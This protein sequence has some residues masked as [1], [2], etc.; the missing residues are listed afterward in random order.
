MIID[1]KILLCYNAPVSIYQVYTGKPKEHDCGV[2]DMSESGFVN[3]LD[4]L[5]ASLKKYFS[6][7]ETLAVSKNI[8]E[9]IRKITA[10][11]PDAIFNLVESV[12]GNAT[13]E[14]FH[15][16]IFDLLDI[17]YTG[18]SPQALGNC[19]NKTFA[20]QIL[21]AHGIKTPGSLTFTSHTHLSQKKFSLQFPVITK[22]A[23]EDA[24]IGISEHSVVSSFENLRK[25]IKF[26]TSTYNQDVI[27]EEYIAGR[28][29]NI[30]VL[31]NR[32]LP[33]SEIDFSGLPDHLPKIVTYEG[34]WISESLY[35]KH[36]NPKCPAKLS[37]YLR[38]N[39][40][41]AALTTFNA[42]ECRDYARVDIRLDKNNIPYVIE[43]NPNPDISTDSGFARAAKASG[44]HYEEMLF[45][46]INL[47]LHRGKRDT[48]IKAG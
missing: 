22:L 30:A 35:Y 29:F 6:R 10:M 41:T 5:A 27:V 44:L 28:E 25:Q 34:K 1:A 45:K 36:T 39:I 14:A 4:R 47:A 3:E 48:Q 11:N 13:F 46:I 24:S 43:V 33:I 38:K 42:M 20:K 26:L 7:V 8:G 37:E 16:G 32:A 23:K 40:E 15:A 17:P 9:S 31:G 2:C 12:E 18:N 21:R 19:L